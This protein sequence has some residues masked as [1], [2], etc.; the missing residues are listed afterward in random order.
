MTA[1]KQINHFNHFRL[2]ID[3]PGGEP[4]Y[5]EAAIAGKKKES[6][7]EC[8][9]EACRMLDAAGLLRQSTHGTDCMD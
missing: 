5:A 3:G 1:K 6:V 8:A 4:L 9:R 2:P 7:L